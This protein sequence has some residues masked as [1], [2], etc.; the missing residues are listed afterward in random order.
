MVAYIWLLAR[1]SSRLH[2]QQ[3][4]VAKKIR[5]SKTD[6]SI[7]LL[8]RPNLHKHVWFCNMLILHLTKRLV[9][10]V[11][12]RPLVLGQIKMYVLCISYK[13]GDAWISKTIKRILNL[14]RCIVCSK[15]RVLNVK[16][17]EWVC[18]GLVRWDMLWLSEI[19]HY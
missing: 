9:L 4:P 3:P 19:G 7:W 6:T 8:A 18:L 5:A 14:S 16:M 2:D 12:K 11:P 1:V 13:S 10:N 15:T 17:L